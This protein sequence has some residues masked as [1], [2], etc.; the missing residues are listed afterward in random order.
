[1]DELRIGILGA[2]RIAPAAVVRPGRRLTGVEVVSVAARDPARARQFA[3]RHRLP[4][5]HD[6]YEAL[7]ADPAIDAVYIPLPT[8]LHG[9]WTLAAIEAGKHVLCEKP[10]AANAEEAAA[11]AGR[12]QS[13]RTVVMEAFHYR[14]HPLTARLLEILGSG[15]LGPL[16]HIEASMCFPLLRRGDIRYDLDLAG[17]ALMDAGC[18]PV[19]LVRTLSGREPTVV[20][21]RA[22]QA[23]R[24]VDRAMRAELALGD[25]ATAT[26]RTSL[27]STDLLGV[28][29]RVRG[30]EGELSVLNPFAPQVFHRLSVRT[31]RGHRVEHLTRQPSYEFQLQAFAFAVRH[32]GPVV[33]SAA[34][35]VCTMALIDDIYRAAGMAPRL[36]TPP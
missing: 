29:A 32:G 26:V 20:S 35:A 18:Y 17:G 31:S 21:A 10:F 25:G 15:E 11:V 33:T 28:S 4:R 7:V 9:R 14:Y 1:M 12:A 23:S 3:E 19:H 34:D 30:A 16:R 6:S 8:G 24:G 2:A 36:P 5:T 27:L 13:G 22:R